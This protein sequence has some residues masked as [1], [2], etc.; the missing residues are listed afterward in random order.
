MRT[1]MRRGVIERQPR[2]NL[3]RLL[4]WSIDNLIVHLERQFEHSMSWSNTSEWEID[5]IVPLSAFQFTSNRSQEFRAAWA[6]TNLAPRWKSD[7]RVKSDKRL[8]LL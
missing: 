4:G 8:Y 2:G 7:N 6:I 1:A 3:E 5:H